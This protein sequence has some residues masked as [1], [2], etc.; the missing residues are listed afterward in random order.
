LGR[1][2]WA[3]EVQRN[4]T[5]GEV[6]TKGKIVELLAIVSL[7]CYEGKLKLGADIHVKMSEEHQILHARELSI[8]NE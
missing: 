1:G 7:Q 6:A 4:A 2:V 3:R 5:R 8:H